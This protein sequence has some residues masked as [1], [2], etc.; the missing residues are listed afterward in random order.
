MRVNNSITGVKNSIIQGDCLKV[1]S[2]LSAGSIDFI[3]TDPPYLVNYKSREGRGV[4]NDDNDTWLRPAFAEM[5]RTLRSDSFCVSFYG[6]TPADRFIWAWRAAGFRLVGH[7]VFPKPYSSRIGIVKYQHEQAYVLAKGRPKEPSH[8]IG[9]VIAWTYSGNKLHPTQKPLCILKPLIQ[10]F[11]ESESLVCDPF[12]GS[13]STCLAAK[14][15]FR[16]YLGIE[17]DPMYAAIAQRRLE[18]VL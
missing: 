16:S 14:S 3:L 4:P 17:L 1:L 2:Q 9:D 15:L 10:A 12:C 18:A 5:Y 8:R 11:S 13:G 6:W 7:L